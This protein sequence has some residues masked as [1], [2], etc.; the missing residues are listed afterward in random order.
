MVSTHGSVVP[1]AM[2]KI[3]HQRLCLFTPTYCKFLCK[4]WIWDA[5]L[6]PR[7]FC[8]PSQAGLDLDHIH[9]H[10][11][12]NQDLFVSPFKQGKVFEQGLGL[13]VEDEFFKDNAIEVKRHFESQSLIIILNRVQNI[14]NFPEWRHL[15]VLVGDG[16]FLF[17]AQHFVK[18][19]AFW[20]HMKNNQTRESETN[21][22]ELM[23]NEET[24]IDN[25][26]E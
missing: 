6:G 8:E 12:R 18:K 7:W 26:I 9:R 5:A 14:C 13:Q 11:Y 24:E 1:L 3:C 4:G 15:D 16:I 25:V 2:F 17:S 20:R 22:R 10:F 23:L 21:T 19:N